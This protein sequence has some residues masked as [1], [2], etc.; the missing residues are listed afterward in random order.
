MAQ[1]E[2]YR[3][4]Q[5]QHRL[6]NFLDRSGLMAGECDRIIR[7]V[8]P[9]LPR[10]DK[11]IFEDPIRTPLER[12]SADDCQRVRTAMERHLRSKKTLAAVVA[13]ERQAKEGKAYHLGP[14]QNS[15]GGS[16]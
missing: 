8:C 14:A 2:L 16:G 12:M 7:R 5:E 3:L 11:C 13:R 15:S 9:H 10:W 1:G 4:R 6:L